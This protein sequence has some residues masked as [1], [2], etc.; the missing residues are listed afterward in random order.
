MSEVKKV[1]AASIFPLISEIIQQGQNTRLTVSGDS[2]YPLLRDGIDSVELTKGS[3]EELSR[4]D[5][6]MVQRTNGQYVMHRVI[7]K[8]MDCFYMVGDAQQWIEGPLY[9]NQLVAVVT[10]LWRKDTRISCSNPILRL[11][12]KIWLFLRPYR[13]FIL[14]VYRKLR[15]IKK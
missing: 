5:I 12:S 15:N 8:E 9:P 6:A 7:R 4:G 10:A 14:R 2:M 1:K 3:F 11:I 13:Y